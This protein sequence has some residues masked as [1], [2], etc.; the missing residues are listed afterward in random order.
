MISS[1]EEG[2]DSY[3]SALPR[4]LV[5][6]PCP[7]LTTTKNFNALTMGFAC[8]DKHFLLPFLKSE[9]KSCIYNVGILP[10]LQFSKTCSLKT[11]ISPPNPVFK[12]YKTEYNSKLV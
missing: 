8:V 6:G 10:E 5:H 1:A 11:F 3:V 2:F 7:V 9:P 12:M 4:N